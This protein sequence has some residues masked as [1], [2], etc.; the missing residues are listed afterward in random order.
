MTQTGL[1]SLALVAAFAAGCQSAQKSLSG[2]E[3]SSL[4]RH[5]LDVL[6]AAIA[7]KHNPAVRIAAVEAMQSVDNEEL[8]PWIRLA[9]LDNHPAVRFAACA[10]VGQIKDETSLGVVLDLTDD[11]NE[12]VRVAALFARHRLGD[13]SQTG[14][15]ADFLLHNQDVSVRRN[16]A[17]LLGMLGE[18]SSITLLAKAMNDTDEGVRNQVLE[19]L[20][21]LG[22]AQ[23]HKELQ[24]MANTGV[25]SEEVFAIAALAATGDPRF[26]DTFRYKLSTA[27]H[28]ETR[29]TAARALGVLG[30][31]DG[32]DFAMQTLRLQR[33]ESVESG[34][35]PEDRLLRV[36]LLAMNALGAIR[37]IDSLANLR[38]VL[39]NE[40]DPRVQVAAARAVL[41]ITVL[42]KDEGPFARRHAAN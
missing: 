36:R 40:K 34:D 41:D 24:F 26:A 30:L 14:M 13:T 32:F 42:P 10:A 2:T 28:V 27:S 31:D 29:L 38:M 18:R 7:Y 3:Q 6:K 37:R 1:Y 19:A 12:S 20:A 4:R 23:A 39:I 5:S 9:L 16:A 8:L 25:G 21:V 11:E 33:P 22:H 15:M 17:M 35:T